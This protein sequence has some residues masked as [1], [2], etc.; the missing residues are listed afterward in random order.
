MKVELQSIAHFTS[1]LPK[2]CGIAT[3]SVALKKTIKDRLPD[4]KD[5]VIAIDDQKDAYRYSTSVKYNFHDRDID[6]YKKAAEVINQSDAQLVDVQHEFGLYGSKVNPTTL[7]QDDGKNFLEFMRALKKPAVTT[8]HMVYENPPENHRQVVREICDRSYKV[9]VLAEVAKDFLVRDYG[10]SPEMVDVIP[11]GAPNVPKYSTTF[12][13]EMMGF[14]R[15][16]FI[17]SSF[18]LVRPK[19]GYEYLVEAMR[20]VV[21]KYPKAKLLI[22]GRAHPQRSP[23]YYQMLK[24]KVRE[25][26][27]TKNVKFI[28]K[29]V[30]YTDLLNYLMAT[31]IFVAPFLVMSQVSS[32]S[33]IY[34]MA[35]G[36][37]CIATPFDYAREA[38]A[39]R[40]GIIV[41]PEDSEELSK[42][43]LHLIDHPVAR[44]RMQNLAYSYAR[45]QTWSKVAKQYIDLFNR[46]VNDKS[47]SKAEII[48]SLSK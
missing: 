4:L 34:A 22:I 35:A 39:D 2:A 30:N 37:A 19:K 18:G 28:N 47:I 3:Y 48:S 11:H 29:F 45:K 17:I 27:L 21:A 38:L 31:N 25:Y 26:K 46:V 14:S 1:Y 24:D 10:I 6:G 42:A 41:P 43:I 40:R 16:D 36:R 7:G 23:E 8:L 13:K 15:D 9:V 32:G 33:L 20:D 5:F 12:F 44:H